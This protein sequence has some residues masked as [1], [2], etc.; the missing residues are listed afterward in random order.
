[1]KK[2]IAS[3]LLALFPLICTGC[4]D[5]DLYNSLMFRDQ[6]PSPGSVR[7]TWLGTAGM[8][9]T[10]GT[11]SI[12]IDPYV[13]RFGMCTIAFGTPLEPDR[14]L[15]RKWADSLGVKNIAAVIV[16][17][18]HFDHA[19]DA[20][21]FAR[22]AGAPLIGTESTMNVGRGAGLPERQLT[23]VKPGRTMK[24]GAFTVRFIESAHGPAFLG[25]IPYPGTIDRP[26]LPPAAA[27]EYRLGGVFSLLISHPLG[28][29]LHHGSA[30]FLPEMYDGI[31]A[32]AVF[33]GITGRKD[34][35]TYLRQV[36]L[37]TG[38]RLVVPI[39]QD[40]FFKPIE[41]GMSFLPTAG[42]GEFCK[43][44]KNHRS[45]F[46]LRTV[47]IGKSTM[48]LPLN[49]TAVPRGPVR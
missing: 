33:L 40:N 3:F 43:T 10:D 17:H 2:K 38:A 15:I 29:I 11:T 26:L 12:L 19:V 9:I 48:I 31:T 37:K 42:F 47:P 35:D 5:S 44:A 25:R 27:R 36:V 39:H 28:T 14:A 18:S 41:D 8:L 13:S 6:A 21:Y 22:A 4:G 23:S 49:D 7:V 46:S 34:T 30:G 20:P 1:M 24:F 45:A 32:D 16:S